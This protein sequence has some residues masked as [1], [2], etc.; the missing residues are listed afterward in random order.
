MGYAVFKFIELKLIRILL[1]NTVL[2]RV[3]TPLPSNVNSLK[4]PKFVDN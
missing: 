2:Y 3:T 4:S 1:Y